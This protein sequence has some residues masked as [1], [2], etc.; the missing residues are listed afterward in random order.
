MPARAG[1]SAGNLA[2]ALELAR[3]PDIHDHDVIVLGGLDGVRRAQGFDFGIGLVDQGLDPAMD[4]LGHCSSLWLVSLHETDMLPLPL[5]EGWGYGLSVPLSP[6]H[7]A[8]YARRS[9]P[10]GER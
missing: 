3:I 5:G 1:K 6:P 10:K 4:G 8:H 7:P 2:V 9:L